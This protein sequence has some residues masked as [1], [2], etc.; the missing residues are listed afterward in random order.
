[1][2]IFV[3]DGDDRFELLDQN[4]TLRED[5]LI[6]LVKDG[7]ALTRRVTAI[8]TILNKVGENADVSQEVY[9]S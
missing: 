8:K 1:M 3:I 4:I 6:E 2:R 7:K 5:E 9:L